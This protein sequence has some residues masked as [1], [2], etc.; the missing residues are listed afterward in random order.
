MDTTSGFDGC[1]RLVEIG[2]ARCALADAA[3]SCMLSMLRVQTPATSKPSIRAIG[4]GMGQAHI[5][6]PDH[7]NPLRAHRT[8]PAQLLFPPIQV[9]LHLQ[10]VVEQHEV[11]AIA[12]RDAAEL[13]IEPQERAPGSSEA[14]RSTSGRARPRRSTLLRTALAMS[15]SEPASVPSAVVSLPSLR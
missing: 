9:C 3:G 6:E 12:R 14:M 8:L 10:A 4:E 1:E 2:E 15:R 7:Q 11:G 13:V 5:A